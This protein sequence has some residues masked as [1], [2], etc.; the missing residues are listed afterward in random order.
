M[1]KGPREGKGVLVCTRSGVGKGS[2]RSVMP[3][4][5]VVEPEHKRRRGDNGSP[6]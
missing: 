4:G 6:K 3:Y 5:T 2:S 1:R